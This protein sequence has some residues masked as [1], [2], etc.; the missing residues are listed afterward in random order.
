VRISKKSTVGANVFATVGSRHKKQLLIDEYGLQESQI[1]Y[2]R[3]SGFA[4]AILTLTDGYGVD[5]VLNSTTDEALRASWECVAAYGRFVEIGKADIN[6]NS[7]LP[8]GGFAQN[9]SFLAV[10]VSFRGREEELIGGVLREVMAMVAE[11]KLHYPKPLH[12][13]E[14]S[15]AEDAFR[16]IQRG[17]NTGRTI[18]RIERTT[19]VQVSHTCE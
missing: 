18:I 19:C 11:G 7:S 1:L 3:N 16:Y 13:F 8:I 2:S 9:V 6:A 4:Q 5:M 14:V 17:D 15:A 10:D 12:I